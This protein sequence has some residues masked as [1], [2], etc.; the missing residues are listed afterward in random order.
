[1]PSQR[2]PK[3]AATKPARKPSNP[4]KRKPA[5]KPKPRR[6]RPPKVLDPKVKK[7]LLSAIARGMSHEQ[8]CDLARID[9]E[10][11]RRWM[12]WGAEGQEPY[13][14]FCGDLKVAEAEGIYRRLERI[15]AGTQGWQGAAWIN[16][17]R[18]PHHFGRLERIEH[19]GPEGGPIAFSATDLRDAR[20]RV[21]AESFP[22]MH[23][24]SAP[25]TPPSEEG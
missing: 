17:R 7:K 8:C 24:P 5:P 12:R 11:F 18:Y 20:A 4:S 3:T 19:S 10:T 9:P 23:I 21:L 14:T 15:E 25:S 13:A 6:G 1:M 16:E 2:K 22:D